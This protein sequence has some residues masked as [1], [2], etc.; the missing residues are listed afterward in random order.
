[1]KTTKTTIIITS[2]I[3]LLL[4]SCQYKNNESKEVNETFNENVSTIK[5]DELTSFENAISSIL[6]IRLPDTIYCG[7]ESSTPINKY[8]DLIIKISPKP[9]EWTGIYGKLP[10]KNDKVYIIYSIVGDIN[11]PYLYTYDRKGNLIDSMYLHIG[12]CLGDESIITSNITI[13]N[14]DFSINMIDTTQYIQY[15]ENNRISIDSI[16][17]FKQKLELNSKGLYYITST[18]KNIL[19][20]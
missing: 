19:L 3:T 17:I 12:V 7:I 20:E 4:V 18:D 11:Y 8:E 2:L 15:S 14:K 10:S 5:S 16:V 9:I 1:M 6:E 13:I